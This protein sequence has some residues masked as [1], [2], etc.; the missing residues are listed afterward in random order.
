MFRPMYGCVNHGLEHNPAP[1]N[2]RHTYITMHAC[3]TVAMT[4]TMICFQVGNPGQSLQAHV[5]PRWHYGEKISR[6]EGCVGGTVCAMYRVHVQG[7]QVEQ[8]R[9]PAELSVGYH[10]HRRCVE[11]QRD[12]RG[13]WTVENDWYR[14]AARVLPYNGQRKPCLHV[15]YIPRVIQ[16]ILWLILFFQ[17]ERF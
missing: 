4:V 1:S 5:L 12:R 2:H 8:N 9:V 6:G 10:L 3:M 7:G 17:L 14:L 11:S 15:N 13:A 16:H